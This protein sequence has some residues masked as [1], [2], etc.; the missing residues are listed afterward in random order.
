MSMMSCM[1]TV[2]LQCLQSGMALLLWIS[3]LS[4]FCRIA[5]ARFPNANWRASMVFDFPLPFAPITAEKFW[6]KGPILR[7]PPYDLKFSQWISRIISRGFFPASFSLICTSC[8]PTEEDDAAP[9]VA[10]VFILEDCSPLCDRFTTFG[11]GG[12]E[13]VEPEDAAVAAAP[14]VDVGAGRAGPVLEPP[15]A[16]ACVRPG[17]GALLQEDEGAGAEASPRGDILLEEA[18]I[19]TAAPSFFIQD[20]SFVDPGGCPTPSLSGSTGSPVTGSRIS[21]TSSCENWTCFT[22]RCL[23]SSSSSGGRS[24]SFFAPFALL[25][26]LL[27]LPCPGSAGG[28]CA[29]GSCAGADAPSSAPPGG[30]S[31]PPAGG[32]SSPPAAPAGPSAA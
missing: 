31:S 17:A 28:A 14:V 10:L 25:Q 11:G 4:L 13:E 20:I 3:S 5:F 19:S 6:W 2:T 22:T 24:V 30:T 27:A 9:V 7:T 8:D 12:A 26:L 21:S 32:G 16:S 18:F 1:K 29:C 15:S 23:A